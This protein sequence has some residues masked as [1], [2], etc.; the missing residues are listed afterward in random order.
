MVVGARVVS[1]THIMVWSRVWC[2]CP[3]FFN[4]LYKA[5]ESMIVIPGSIHFLILLLFSLV[6][7]LESFFLTRFPHRVVFF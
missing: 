7:R 4:G 1:F 2:V 5:Q 6:W 3:S